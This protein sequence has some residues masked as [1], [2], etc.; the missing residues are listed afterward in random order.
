MEGPVIYFLSKVWNLLVW[1]SLVTSEELSILVDKTHFVSFPPANGI[2]EY[3]KLDPDSPFTS[4][5]TLVHPY[6]MG[7]KCT[8]LP[9]L[10]PRTSNLKKTAPKRHPQA[11]VRKWPRFSIC[12][13]RINIKTAGRELANC[14]IRKN[15]QEKFINQLKRQSLQPN[16]MFK[17]VLLSLFHM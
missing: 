14:N 15:Y 6:S 4:A 1:S 17:T 5:V 8:E 12:I 3:L 2:C 10:A 11:S 13:F 9:C 7:P 16:T